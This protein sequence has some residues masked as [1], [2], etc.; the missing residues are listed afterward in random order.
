MEYRNDIAT[1][2]LLAEIEKL[3]NCRGVKI[4]TD[5]DVSLSDDKLPSIFDFSEHDAKIRE[6]MEYEVC[7]L[8][9]ENARLEKQNADI[10]D[11]HT[12]LYN[13][14]KEEIRR[15]KDENTALKAENQRSNDYLKEI[16]NS[17]LYAGRYSES[18]LEK[19]KELLRKLKEYEKQDPPKKCC[20]NCSCEDD[21]P[22]SDDELD[23]DALIYELQD[24]HQKDCIRVNDLT[25]TV[26]V[27]S[28]LYVNLRKNV[29]MD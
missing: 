28:R 19:N 21:L 27:L 13:D 23:V 25:T 15:L 18:L 29:G 26:N 10:Q 5:L 4:K 1:I 20:G 2:I 24:Q 9:E 17:L 11:S 14:T 3:L 7:R 8:A 12:K 6:E 16:E 22:F